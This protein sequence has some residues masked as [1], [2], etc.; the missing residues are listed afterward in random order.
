MIKFENVK[1]KFE[2][3]FSEKLKEEYQKLKLTNHN[4]I[5]DFKTE[6]V[7]TRKKA[8]WYSD[9]IIVMMVDDRYIVNFSAV[10]LVSGFVANKNKVEDFDFEHG[11]LKDL[12]V[13]FGIDNDDKV[14]YALSQDKRDKNADLRLYFEYGRWLEILVEDKEENETY[15]YDVDDIA[16]YVDDFDLE[17]ALSCIPEFNDFFT[18]EGFKEN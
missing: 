11:C 9:S 4:I 10:G 14:E 8:L 5:V 17:Y 12:L 13:D 18:S 1:T 7:E 3:E 16:F 15:G 6:L 2:K